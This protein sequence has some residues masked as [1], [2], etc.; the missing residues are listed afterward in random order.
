MMIGTLPGKGNPRMQKNWRIKAKKA[1][2][3]LSCD[4]NK[5]REYFHSSRM[6]IHPMGDDIL[7]VPRTGFCIFTEPIGSCHTKIMP[8]ISTLTPL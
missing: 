3:F 8:Y 5:I 7:V 1:V 2:S 4:R 6:G